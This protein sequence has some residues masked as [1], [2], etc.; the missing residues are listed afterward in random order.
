[1]NTITSLKQ[2]KYPEEECSYSC[3]SDSERNSCGSTEDYVFDISS[4][5]TEEEEENIPIH[6]KVIDVIDCCEY[7]NEIVYLHVTSKITCYS[8]NRYRQITNN[9]CLINIVCFNGYLYGLDN[10][11]LYMLCND[12][13]FDNYWV[14]K[15]VCWAPKN[16]IYINSNLNCEYLLI[17]T[18]DKN[19]IYHDNKYKEL[20]IK[21]RRIYGIDINSYID[22][23][24]TTAYVYVNDVLVKTF[25]NVIDAA[26]NYNHDVYVVRPNE[27]CHVKIINY[28]AYY[29]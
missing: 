22:I 13:F 4:R 15:K 17:Q 24:H 2:L 7:S 9:R 18:S 29:F 11:H 1:M 28:S 12:Y 26:M 6:P 14:W 3:S 19:Y 25:K 21:G 5:S 27:S 8:N 23:L 10:K 16:I 20:S